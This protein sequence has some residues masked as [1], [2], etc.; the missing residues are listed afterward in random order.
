MN[1]SLTSPQNALGEIDISSRR[2]WSKKSAISPAQS[3]GR[4]DALFRGQGHNPFDEQRVLPVR[5]HR[6]RARTPLAAFFN[7]PLHFILEVSNLLIPIT[8]TD[9]SLKCR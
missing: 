7:I 5:E 3:R 1:I 8:T 9:V 2:E 6:K 4:Q